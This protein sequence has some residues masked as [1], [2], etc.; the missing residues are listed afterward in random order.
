MRS[1]AMRFQDMLTDLS[2]FA[3]RLRFLV[4]DKAGVTDPAL[5][6]WFQVMKGRPFETIHVMKQALTIDLVVRGRR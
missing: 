4:A 1:E 3:T 2:S 6:V 5:K